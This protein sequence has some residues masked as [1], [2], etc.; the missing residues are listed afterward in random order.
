MLQAG[1]IANVHLPKDRITQTHQGYGFVEFLSDSD[2]L[3]ASQIMTGIRLFGKPMRVNKAS[4]DKQRALDV[5]A[6]LFIGNLDPMVD[7]KILYDTFGRFGSLIQAPKV[8]KDDA[9]LSKGYGFV[10]FSQFDSSDDAI[11]GMDGQWLM[12]REITVQYAYKKDG[13]GERH[14]DQAERMLAAEAQK[15]GV[16]FPNQPLPIVGVP[17]VAPVTPVNGDRGVVP[18]S[19]T[20]HV[21]YMNGV[22]QGQPPPF[23]NMGYGTPTPQTYPVQN[24]LLTRS[25]G[26]PPMPQGFPLGSAPSNGFPTMPPGFQQPS[27]NDAQYPPVGFPGAMAPPPLPPGFGNGQPGMALPSL[28]SRVQLPPGYQ[29][30]YGNR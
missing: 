17:P 12:N 19:N 25:A 1:R 22:T 13:K 14:G 27:R 9:N 28:P 30:G 24:G 26:L 18:I 6:E 7:E 5:G 21:P 11:R 2:A 4:A 23:S 29:Q 20:A 8:A 10:S 3:Y 15:H 16:Q